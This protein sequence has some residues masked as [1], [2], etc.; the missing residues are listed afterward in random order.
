MH[1]FLRFFVQGNKFFS[2]KHMFNAAISEDN[3]KEKGDPDSAV[4]TGFPRVETH[5]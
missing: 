4:F 1:L 5:K 2:H 3:L